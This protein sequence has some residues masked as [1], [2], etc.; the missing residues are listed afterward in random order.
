MT[1]AVVAS[2]KKCKG[3]ATTRKHPGGPRPCSQTPVLGSDYCW[4]H[5]EG[6]QRSNKTKPKVA[7]CEDEIGVRTV[8]LSPGDYI[9]G[10]VWRAEDGGMHVRVGLNVGDREAAIQFSDAVRALMGTYVGTNWMVHET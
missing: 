8:H 1:G 6:G 7:R 3:W 5:P 4:Y 9:I 10:T 2:E